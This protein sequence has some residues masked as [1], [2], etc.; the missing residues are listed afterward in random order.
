MTSPTLNLALL[1]SAC[2]LPMEKAIH[3]SEYRSFLRVLKNT[4]EEKGVTQ[5]ELADRL[6]KQHKAITQSLVSKLERGEVRLDVIQ[7]RWI[8]G[9]LGVPLMSFIEKL[10]AAI[11]S[12]VKR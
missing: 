8:C 7:L 10:E 6:S 1:L 9:A 12:R 5:V 2:N 4:R 11:P 3:S